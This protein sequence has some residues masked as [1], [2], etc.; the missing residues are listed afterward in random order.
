MKL[1][2]LDEELNKKRREL[3]LAENGELLK[4][5]DGRKVEEELRIL[6]TKNSQLGADLDSWIKRKGLEENLAKDGDNL[7]L[8]DRKRHELLEQK[9]KLAERLKESEREY[10]DHSKWMN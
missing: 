9:R 8:A 10:E 1:S 3:D 7:E 4:N 5:D 6:K 2:R